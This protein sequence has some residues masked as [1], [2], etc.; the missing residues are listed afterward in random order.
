M[1]TA[2]LLDPA[3]T[4]G[5]ELAPL[6]PLAVVTGISP[7]ATDM[8]IPGLPELAAD[9]HTSAAVAQL[10]LTA[11]LVAF[12]GG[13]LLLGPLSDAIGRRRLVLLG[14][15]AFAVASVL[16]AISPTAPVL[17][18]ARI[19][20]GL[21]G[22]AG[23]VAGRA[24]VTD[25]LVG[26]RR[27]RVIAALSAINA[28]APV[29]APLIGGALLGIGTWRLSFWLLAAVGVLLFVAVVVSFPET[30]APDRRSEG[31]GLIASG[32]RM[33]S[34]L[35]IPRF[36]LYLA[37]SCVATVGFFAYI[38][39]SSFVF[40]TYYGYSATRYTLVFATNASCMIISTL[41]FG[42]IVGR[43]S[44]D[45]LLTV[46]LAVATVASGGVLAGALLHAPGGVVWAFLAVVT[47]A[48]GLVITG[49]VTR[50]Q[51][52]GQSAPG[53]AA[54]LA[55]GLAFGV[56]GLGTPLAG[57]LGGTPTAMGGIMLAGLGLG[58]ALQTLGPRWLGRT[59]HAGP[60]EEPSDQLR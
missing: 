28:V 46:G 31:V 26:V 4:G 56:G 47:G 43:V 27:A 8:Y 2:G 11:F 48:Q 49:S 16:C 59:G 3:R 50:T 18:A 34:L 9:L 5:R 45:R 13:Q 21:A 25:V 51:A 30:L 54:A 36:S 41:I 44:E 33:G 10:T 60:A 42:K 1:P 39:T 35:R 19:V 24:M 22:A 6:V 37:T 7:L 58:L 23:S 20:Q 40:Q 12:A 32:R 55:G 38:A 52:L 14:T 15:L 29:V 17:V 53:S 57:L